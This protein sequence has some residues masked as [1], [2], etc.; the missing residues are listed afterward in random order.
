[1][2][3]TYRAE[4]NKD[5]KDPARLLLPIDMIMG[6]DKHLRTIGWRSI[7]LYREVS[8]NLLTPAFI[9]I[10]SSVSPPL[11]VSPF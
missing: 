11:P 8:K 3:N 2:V 9:S 5:L 7:Q 10:R 1:M 6:H 4:M